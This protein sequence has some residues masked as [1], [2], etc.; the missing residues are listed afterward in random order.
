MLSLTTTSATT[1]TTAS[2]RASVNTA[3]T[4]RK[5][6][7]ANA[8]ACAAAAIPAVSTASPVTNAHAYG[9]LRPGAPACRQAR[10]VTIAARYTT[11]NTTTLTSDS[12]RAGPR[13]AD[14]A[15][16]HGKLR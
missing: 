7:P 9:I 12:V 4:P 6:K 3:V 13:A 14:H 8:E 2:A 16:D 1:T 5:T 11:P 10:I 15:V